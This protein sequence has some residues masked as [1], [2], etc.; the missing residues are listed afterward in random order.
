MIREGIGGRPDGVEEDDDGLA[1]V[2]E[3]DAELDAFAD[4]ERVETAS[5]VND[6]STDFDELLA[7]TVAELVRDWDLEL[8]AVWAELLDT[9]RTPD[10][11]REDEMLETD[12]ADCED[13]REDGCKDE[14]VED[15]REDGE[16]DEDEEDEREID[17]E[18]WELADLTVI[19]WSDVRKDELDRAELDAT[20]VERLLEEVPSGTKTA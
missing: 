4:E 10:T 14:E 13:E 19:A 3:E 15:D 12:L 11:D 8:D 5:T 7:G 16:G 17:E 9:D 2:E 18:D 20:V 1:E 6:L